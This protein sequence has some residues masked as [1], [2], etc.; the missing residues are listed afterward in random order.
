MCAAVLGR[1][2]SAWPAPS[3]G[4]G[5]AADDRRPAAGAVL[6]AGVASVWWRGIALAREEARLRQQLA[7]L[8]RMN[9]VFIPTPPRPA[10][11]A[12]SPPGP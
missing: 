3:V 7:R 11:V 4:G 2:A 6:F 1:N 12:S 10:A 9:E 5:S 8:P